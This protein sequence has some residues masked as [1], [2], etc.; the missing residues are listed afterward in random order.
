MRNHGNFI[1]SLSQLTAWLAQ[2]AEAAGID[3]FAGFAADAS[4]DSADDLATHRR[5]VAARLWGRAQYP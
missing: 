3:V 4:A 2:Q 1:V 5:K